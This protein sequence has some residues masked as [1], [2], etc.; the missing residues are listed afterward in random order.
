MDVFKAIKKRAA[1]KQTKTARQFENFM[2]QHLIAPKDASGAL[3]FLPGQYLFK[4]IDEGGREMTKALSSGQISRAFRDFR[5]DTGWFERRVLRYCE[6]PE[7]N[8]FLSFEPAALRRIFVEIDDGEIKKLKLPLPALVLLGKGT[9]YFL[10]SA[11]A[12]RKITPDTAL[13]VAPLPNVGGEF[14]GKVCFG[15]NDVPEAR[16]E[17]IDTV[18]DLIFDTPFNRDHQTQKCK[19]YPDDVRKLLFSLSEN[20]RKSFPSSEL[21]EST[22]TIANVWERIVEEKFGGYF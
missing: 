13:A 9:D 16:A 17:N 3:Y 15:K 10:W 8:A 4:Q 7:G 19:S 12:K 22:T 5:A 6:K 14:S 18:W 2:N 20:N 21:I 11:K 1:D